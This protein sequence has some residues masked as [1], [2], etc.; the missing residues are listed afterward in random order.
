MAPFLLSRALAGLVWF[1]TRESIL[2]AL[3]IAVVGDSVL[4]L[5]AVAAGVLLRSRR[6][7]FVSTV[8]AGAGLVLGAAAAVIDRLGYK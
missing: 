5:C 4:T 2:S 3:V 1:S 6:L 8:F 7:W